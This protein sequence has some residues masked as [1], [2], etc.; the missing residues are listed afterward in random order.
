MSQSLI[1]LLVL[2]FASCSNKSGSNET[3]VSKPNTEQVAK[4]VFVCDTSASD[5]PFTKNYKKVLSVWLETTSLDWFLEKRQMAWREIISWPQQTPKSNDSMLIKCLLEQPQG[6]YLYIPHHHYYNVY[7]GNEYLYYYVV[8]NSADT[9]FIPR[10]ENVVDSVYS[11]VSFMAPDQRSQPW[12]AFQKS[13]I[14]IEC[15]NSKIYKSALPPKQVM[16]LYFD[17]QYMNLGDT[18]VNYKLGM[19]LPNQTIFSN[20][21]RIN[22]MKKQLPFLGKDFT[23]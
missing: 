11:L 6:A 16:R 13:V 18:T 17:C 10:I 15:G 7:N 4:P 21:I 9:I 5:K 19:S 1:I 23:E 8:N 14:P 20:T 22:L 3:A 2:V 12:V